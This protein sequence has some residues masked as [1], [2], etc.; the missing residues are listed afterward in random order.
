MLKN[1][2]CHIVV[3]L[4]ILLMAKWA[5]SK[6]E[7]TNLQCTSFDKSF[8]DFE[9]CYIR[10]ANRSYKY[11]TLKVNLFKTPRFNGYRPFM[12]NIT[13]DACRFLK[14]TDSKPIAKYF[15]E[16]F[17]SYSNLNHSCPFNHDLIV[18]KIPIDFV[19]HRVTNILP[20]PEGDYLLE[21]H[22]IAYEIDRAMVKIYYTIS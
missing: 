19:N 5:S 4:V 13:L 6:F 16:F 15:Y 9:Y 12:F 18:D 1:T 17:N 2:R 7:F 21:T 20:F 8:D 10:S 11:L 14:N 3:I 22:W